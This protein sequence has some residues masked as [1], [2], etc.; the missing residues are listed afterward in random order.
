NLSRTV[1]DI[2]VRLKLV[3]KIQVNLVYA[4]ALWKI[5]SRIVPKRADRLAR[6][7][8]QLVAVSLPEYAQALEK[9]GE[10]VSRKIFGKH[11]KCKTQDNMCSF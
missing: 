2:L 7:L 1:R 6:T 11:F 4:K 9:Q 10:S 3:W 8:Q 5:Q